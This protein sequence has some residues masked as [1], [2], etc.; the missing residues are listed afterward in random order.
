M[1]YTSQLL[2]DKQFSFLSKVNYRFGQA[3]RGVSNVASKAA[4]GIKSAGQKLDNLA[5]GK[6][7]GAVDKV[8]E[9]GNEHIVKPYKK[10][11]GIRKV[12]KP[13][14]P[15]SFNYK[16]ASNYQLK[17]NA[18]NLKRGQKEAAKKAGDFAKELGTDLLLDQGKIPNKVANGVL[19]AT[20][21]V[22]HAPAS[23]VLNA[24]NYAGAAAGVVPAAV[25]A[26]PVSE[27]AGGIIDTG[28]IP[29]KAR[30]KMKNWAKNNIKKYNDSSIKKFFDKHEGFG[31]RSLG[32]KIKDHFDNLQYVKQ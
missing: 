24:A 14:K 11:M 26:S 29:V 23:T 1:I 32:N 9:F 27:I 4:N 3:H 25:A 31:L 6:L 10:M 18:V 21:A 20:K 7:S 15:E 17:R 16:D 12:A 30:I 2:K 22:T 28:L 13:V 19:Q 8:G 5:G